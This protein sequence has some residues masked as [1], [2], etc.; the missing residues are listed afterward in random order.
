MA[1]KKVG[2]LY[3]GVEA[4]PKG[5]EGVIGSVAKLGLAINGI[6]AIYK[7]AIG[8]V[9]DLTQAF[10]KQQ[11]ADVALA[12]ALK[13]TGQYSQKS[14]SDLKNYAS[15][16]Q[17]ITTVGDETSESLM[18]MAL[19]MGLSSE[20]AKE[21]TK[22]A[23]AMNAAFGIDLKSGVKYASLAMQG[24][25]TMLARYIPQLR[26]VKNE[27]EGAAKFQKAM[28]D[29]FS[30]ATAKTKTYA[31][32]MAQ[33][34][35]VIGDVKEILGSLLADV[36][37]P[38][39]TKI[40]DFLTNNEDKIGLYTKAFKAMFVRIAGGFKVLG[41][42]FELFW[43]SLRLGFAKM[44]RAIITGMTNLAN[45]I[46]D[47]LIKIAE[48]KDKIFHTD[49][50]KE[51]KYFK[52]QLNSFKAGSDDLVKDLEKNGENIVNTIKKIREE[53]DKKIANIVGRFQFLIG[54]V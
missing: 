49:T 40:K 30:V 20:K 45:G 22:D 23:I 25:Y 16:L 3:L 54:K 6:Q 31:G 5:F 32:Q 2:N 28:A 14:Y 17:K 44:D 7:A 35:N 11:D 48:V 9:K 21:A 37:T 50:A 13:A 33:M 27:A 26:G 12:A 10:S 24:Q 47:I 51:L 42:Q 19:N 8:P 46:I 52:S 4:K 34:Q 36:L 29:A 53:Y 38:I 39:F 1:D 15:E 18:Q 41:K 43:N